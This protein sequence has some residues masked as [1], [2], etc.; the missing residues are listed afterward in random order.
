MTTP[1]ASAPTGL[2]RRKIRHELTRRAVRVTTVRRLTRGMIRV[3]VAGEDLADFQ[4]PGPADHLKIFLPDPDRPDHSGGELVNRDYTPRAFRPAGAAP[5]SISS[6]EPHVP[7]GP[8]QAELDLDIVLHGDEGPASAWAAHAA[9]GDPVLLG[10]P[11]GSFLIDQVGAAA[12]LVADET[13][14]PAVARMIEEL[15]GR[16]PVTAMLAP[17]DPENRTYFGD[18][19]TREADLRWFTG[20]GRS[21]DLEEAVRALPDQ[22]GRWFFLAGET[23]LLIPLRRHLR[24]ERGLPASQVVAQGYWKRGVA[25]LDHHAPLDPDDPD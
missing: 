13:G 19:D 11:R 25:A 23:G 12:V 16:V 18:V 2:I 7:T 5:S 4:A 6:T 22:D 20:P 3:T 8:A 9:P 14:F 10:G 15:R 24:H 17:A 21:T 1:Q